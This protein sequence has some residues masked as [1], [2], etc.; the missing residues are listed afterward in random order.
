MESSA[1]AVANVCNWL[2]RTQDPTG[3]WGYQGSDPGTFDRVG[4]YP[5]Q[6]S[7]SRR[8]TEQRVHLR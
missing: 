1:D 8:G 2:L 5:V 6:H 3:G 4:Q 7:L